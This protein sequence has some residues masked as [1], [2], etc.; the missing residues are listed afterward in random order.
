M[1]HSY[2]GIVGFLAVLAGGIGYLVLRIKKKQY[3]LLFLSIAFLLRA[4]TDYLF[5]MLFCDCAI[6]FMIMDAYMA[7]V[8]E[9]R[10][11]RNN[12]DSIV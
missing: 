1:T 8:Y 3:D 4:T 6:L 2:M 11:N 12:C 10:K 5:P 9:K 7:Y